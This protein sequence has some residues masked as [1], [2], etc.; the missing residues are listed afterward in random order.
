MRIETPALSENTFENIPLSLV[1][2]MTIQGTVN[3][4]AILLFFLL[5]S[6]SWVWYQFYTLN[7]T[8]NVF[9]YMWIGAIGGF[10]VALFTIFVKEWAP[11]AAPIYALLEG[12]AI[13]GVSAIFES[14][15]PGIVIQAVGLTFG[16]LFVLLIAYKFGYIE[17][18]DKFMFGVVIATGAVALIY[19]VEI[20][21]YSFTGFNIPYIHESGIIGIGFSLL[22][23]TIA[24]LNLILDFE[25]IKNGVENGAPKYMEWYAAFALMVTLVWLYLEI[26]ELL[27]K[28]RGSE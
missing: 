11:I 27:A 5:L 22:V 18:T 12:L 9:V 17:V 2:E 19:V 15:F 16:T 4:T 21:I 13:G 20:A 1:N 28:L 24:A 8:E 3:K 10:F 26:L 23:I 14:V 7:D 6:A 25:M